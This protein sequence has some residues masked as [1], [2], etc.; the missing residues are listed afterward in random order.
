MRLLIFLFFFFYCPS[1]FGQS[2]HFSIPHFSDKELK[3][4]IDKGSR[5]DTIY[6][7]KLNNFGETN[8]NFTTSEENVSLAFSVQNSEPI[9]ILYNKNE[10]IS[11]LNSTKELKS[12][13]FIIENSPTNTT[14][15]NCLFQL[16]NLENKSMLIN[17]MSSLYEAKNPFLKELFNEKNRIQQKISTINDSLALSTTFEAKYIRLKILANEITANTTVNNIENKTTARNHFINDVDFDLLYSSGF[18]VPIVR[19]TLHIYNESAPFYERFGDDVISIL[20]KIKKEE[21]FET[22]YQD[23]LFISDNLDWVKDK[24]NIENYLIQSGRISDENLLKFKN[25]QKLHLGKKS[26]KLQLPNSNNS[27]KNSANKPEKKLSMLLF[28]ETGCNHCEEEIE[29]VKQNFSLLKNNDVQFISFSSDTDSAAFNE[30]AKSLPWSDNFCSLKGME[31]PNF[32]NFL[33]AVTPTFY[34]INNNGYIIYKTYQFNKVM[35][36]LNDFLKQK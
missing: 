4:W 22:F 13:S 8:I 31:D 9:R 1:F 11:I 30:K 19:S 7:Q 29:K 35:S 14:I 34:I 2:I 24:E 6:K 36:F 23:A 12:N 16:Q 17:K 33:V 3:C 32:K 20:K 27:K 10:N 28:Y 15:F 21:I 18:W 25:N 26:P 5:A